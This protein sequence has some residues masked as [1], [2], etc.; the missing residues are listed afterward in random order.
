MC[1]PIAAA[2]GTA[3]A[4][5]NTMAVVSAGISAISVGAGIVGQQQQLR[6]QAAQAQYQANERNRQLAAQHEQAQ[7]TAANRREQQVAQYVGQVQAQQA[8]NLS[9][10]KQIGFNNEAANRVFVAEQTK[11]QEARD[12]A[13]FKS[14]Q[15]Y[16][17][18]IGA[19][20]SVLAAGRTGQSYGLLA[21]DTARQAGFAQAEQNASLRSARAASAV[22][23]EGGRLQSQSANNQALSGLPAPVV[24][25]LLEMAPAGTGRDLGLGIPSYNWA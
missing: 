1:L 17:K 23:M 8:A 22:A 10:N 13:A 21:Q 15:I 18:Q 16:A 5:T 12:K 24:H 19:L 20:G 6:A 14:Q 3:A 25:P 11:E 2:A 4:F 7:R 9:Y